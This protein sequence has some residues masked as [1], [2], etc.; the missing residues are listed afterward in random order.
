MTTRLV[1]VVRD[2]GNPGR[3]EAQTCG[4]RPTWEPDGFAFT[5]TEGGPLPAHLRRDLPECSLGR[6]AAATPLPPR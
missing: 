1:V 3:Q 4:H 6:R 2:A 5:A